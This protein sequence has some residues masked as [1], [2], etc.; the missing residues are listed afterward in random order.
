[1]E[2]SEPTESDRLAAT[3]ESFDEPSG[4]GTVVLPDGRRF[5]FHCV[6]IRDGSRRIAEGTPVTVVVGFRVARL[7]ATDIAP[8]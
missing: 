2:L 3:V 8:A 6:S 5:P 4:L 1:M 7:E